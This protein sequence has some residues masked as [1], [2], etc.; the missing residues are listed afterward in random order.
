L[1]RGRSL[2]QRVESAAGRALRD[3][4]S[5]SLVDVFCGI[6]WLP[7]GAVDR[8][9]QGRVETLEQVMDVGPEKLA[10]ALEIM[11]NWARSAG[12]VPS[13][14][15]Y[16]AATRGPAAAEV[17]GRRRRW[18]GGGVPDALDLTRAVRGEA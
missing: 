9:R 14:I 6:G 15:D 5:V 11:G 3:S 13:E 12:L 2:A 8:W 17:P 10:E 18:H 7:P 1:G 16:L 4:K